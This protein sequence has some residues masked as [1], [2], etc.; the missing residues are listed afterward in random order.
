[1]KLGPAILAVRDIGPCDANVISDPGDG[2][3]RGECRAGGRGIAAGGRVLA[4]D[5]DHE[6]ATEMSRVHEIQDR[7]AFWI[8]R[9]M[10][11]AVR[12]PIQR[13]DAAVDRRAP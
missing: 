3:P 5:L 8:E 6:V 2:D 9:D 12:C 4:D 13:D 1:M 10:Q 7:F 11:I